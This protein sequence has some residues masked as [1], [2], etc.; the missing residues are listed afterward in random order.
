MP[1]SNLSL[2][3]YGGNLTISNLYATLVSKDGFAWANIGATAETLT[4][5]GTNHLTNV[6]QATVFHGSNPL[7]TLT[8]PGSLT[9]AAGPAKGSSALVTGAS[10]VISNAADVTFLGSGTNSVNVWGG[11]DIINSKVTSRVTGE[12]DGEF[13]AG[14]VRIENSTVDMS[15]GVLNP[16][17]VGTNRWLG[18][19]R[20]HVSVA[21]K[22][23]DRSDAG[24]DCN[25]WLRLEGDNS[26]LDYKNIVP[27]ATHPGY[28]PFEQEDLDQ[29]VV[30]YSSPYQKLGPIQKLYVKTDKVGIASDWQ[31]DYIQLTWTNEVGVA[32]T[33]YFNVNH[34]FTGDTYGPLTPVDLGN[35]SGMVNEDDTYTITNYTHSADLNTTVYVPARY[36][37]RAVTRLGAYLFLGDTHVQEVVLPSSVQAIGD[38]AFFGCSGLQRV[39]M[40]PGV[41]SLG[42]WAFGN[43]TGLSMLSIPAGLTHVGDWAF[44]GCDQLKVYFHGA[45]PSLAGS[46]G[47]VGGLIGGPR[48]FYAPGQPG[49]GPTWGGCPTE[50]WAPEVVVSGG[51]GRDGRPFSFQ[52]SGAANMDVV[53]GAC[54]DLGNPEWTTLRT[55]TLTNGV[56]VFSDPDSTNYAV[57][58]YNLSMP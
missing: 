44:N 20:D 25:I 52:I 11:L 26:T 40:P 16:V 2:K 49:W 48:I 5:Q 47:R 53:I 55:S 1:L 24:T 51:S 8:G 13:I 34:K 7:L 9:V 29:F 36:G 6:P 12:S 28:D 39:T 38:Y 41:V 32:E 18:N 58:F 30:S 15:W 23:Y 19:V 17:L 46:Y 45:A 14:I 56:M 3:L 31:C 35:F 33:Y 42:D 10:L 21:V 50:A 27:F 43:C 57:R 22:T 4:I 37:G 54:P